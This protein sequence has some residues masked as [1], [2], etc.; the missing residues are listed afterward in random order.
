VAKKYQFGTQQISVRADVTVQM[1]NHLTE[2]EWQ[3]YSPV[4][5][6][7]WFAKYL[8]TELFPSSNFELV[9]AD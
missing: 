1:E 4:E 7:E 5:Q 2:A 6:E 9:C 8:E 3:G